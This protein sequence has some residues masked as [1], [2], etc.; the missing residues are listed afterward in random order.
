MTICEPEFPQVPECATDERSTCEFLQTN[1][2]SYH[3][4]FLHVNGYQDTPLFFFL[5]FDSLYPEDYTAGY[6]PYVAD[7]DP[8]KGTFKVPGDKF[9][10]DYF[11]AGGAILD[12]A[13]LDSRT[14][15][16]PGCA[17]P[18]FVPLTKSIITGG[19]GYYVKFTPLAGEY[20]DNYNRMVFVL[21]DSTASGTFQVVTVF[22]NILP[23][24]PAGA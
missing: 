3:Y 9:Q 13:G 12:Q 15:R 1:D 2:V 24:S 17:V 10:A 23:S 11:D 6:T 21:E 16:D 7:C 22:I 5:D 19:K 4:S 8:A 14:N 20:G 18:N